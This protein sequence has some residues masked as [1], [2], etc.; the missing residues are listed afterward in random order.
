M[1]KYRIAVG[2][3]TGR[4]STVWRLWTAKADFYLQ[5]LNMGGSTK[6]SIHGSGKAQWSMQSDWYA[7]NRPNQPNQA[8]HIE[9]WSWQLPTLHTASHVFRLFIPESE[10]R[11]IDNAEV[12][13]DVHWLPNPGT[14]RKVVVECHVSPAVPSAAPV[15]DPGF[16]CALERD[17]GG[18]V[19][20]FA[21][22]LAVSDHDL[23]EVVRV[24]KAAT[25]M[26]TQHSIVIQ[27][28]YRLVA[29]TVDEYGTRGMI[30]FVP[31]GT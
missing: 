21:R 11:L 22:D 16:L 19:V 25:E 2:D 17:G 26:A 10:L 14:G 20:A 18:S 3:A 30:E 23:E 29:L 13:A 9:K 8:R 27:P 4:R 12:L 28:G 24:Q 7:L 15:N 6:V 31:P 5:S 1:R